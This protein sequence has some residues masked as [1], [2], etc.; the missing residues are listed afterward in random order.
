[1]NVRGEWHME[2]DDHRLMAERFMRDQFAIMK[3]FGA[4]PKIDP[5]RY[6]QAVSGT[7]RTLERFTH[8]GLL[9]RRKRNSPER[10]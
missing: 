8:P 3:K 7:Q 5:A 9:A 2:K 4:E 1:M 6:E 10:A